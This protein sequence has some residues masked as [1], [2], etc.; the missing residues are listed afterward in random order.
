[1]IKK[2][3]LSLVLTAALFG[4]TIP[5]PA[6]EFSVLLPTGKKI[7]LTDYKGKVILLTG[8]LTT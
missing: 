3:A 1:M 5:R 6:P 4:Q 2:L 7:S 8:L